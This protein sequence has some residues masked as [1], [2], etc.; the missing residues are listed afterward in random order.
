MNVPL[1]NCRVPATVSPRR[2]G[3]PG[4]R[5]P[6]GLAACPCAT[7]SVDFSALPPPSPPP[8]SLQD[9]HD[10]NW[11]LLEFV[12]A[13]PFAAGWKVGGVSRLLAATL[14]AE[15]VTCWPFWREWPTPSYSVHVR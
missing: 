11:L 7:P 1:P 12:L 9:G 2:S 13:I 5:C 10:N 4:T 3:C 14:V 8:A 15:A 6:G